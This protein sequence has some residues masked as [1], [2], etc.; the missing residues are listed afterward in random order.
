MSTAHPFPICCGITI[1]AG[2]A[3]RTGTQKL[4]PTDKAALEADLTGQISA[5]RGVG[6]LLIALNKHQVD[7]GYGKVAASLKFLRMGRYFYH[8]GHGNNIQLYGYYYHPDKI[9]EHPDKKV[10]DKAE[11]SV[12]KAGVK[13]KVLVKKAL[14]R[15]FS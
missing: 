5:R 3:N 7:S 14:K 9:V 15:V 1:I 10:T 13:K 2:F 12:T 4:S 6:L 8:P 11:A